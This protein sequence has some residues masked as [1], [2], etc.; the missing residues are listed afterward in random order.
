M[1]NIELIK[2]L[3]DAFKNK[4]T[5][6]YP[7]L[8]DENIEWITMDGMPNGGRYVGLKAIFGD[9]FPGML[10]NFSEFHAV[11]EQFLDSTDHVIVIGRYLGIS[12]K[13]RKV[14]VPFS[15]VY[16]IKNNK[17]IKFRQFTDTKKI[18]DSIV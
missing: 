6:K 14:D 7:V 18:Q 1:S 15:H 2:K 8:C 3:Y 11:T 4:D 13:G 9:Y 12:K 16:Q 10:K 17:I 5:E